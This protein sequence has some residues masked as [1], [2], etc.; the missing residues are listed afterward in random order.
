MMQCPRFANQGCFKA[1]NKLAE[2]GTEVFPT[3]FHKGCSMF[4]FVDREAE[5]QA[6][7]YLGT[8]CREHC[9]D[10]DCNR[11]NRVSPRM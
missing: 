2:D 7:Q 6:N 5:C 10:P 11:E 1:D 8:V 9:T 4:E 3:G